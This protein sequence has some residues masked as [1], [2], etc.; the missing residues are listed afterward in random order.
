MIDI[1]REKKSKKREPAEQSE[2]GFQQV[3]NRLPY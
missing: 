2:N 1:K 3:F